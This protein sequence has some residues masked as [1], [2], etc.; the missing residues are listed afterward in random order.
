MLSHT[1]L[2]PSA[3]CYSSTSSSS[4]GDCDRPRTCISRVF[5][6]RLMLELLSPV[7]SGRR[8]L[9]YSGPEAGSVGAATFAAARFPSTHSSAVPERREPHD[10]D[11]A[12]ATCAR[13]HRINSDRKYG[14]RGG[15]RRRRHRRRGCRAHLRHRTLAN[16]GGGNVSRVTARILGGTRSWNFP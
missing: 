6:R 4:V 14:S 13:S 11:L 7:R 5:S 1:R 12:I 3:S 8:A 9:S 2:P 15:D 16:P 10:L